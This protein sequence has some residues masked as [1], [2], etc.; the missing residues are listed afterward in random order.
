MKRSLKNL[1]GFPLEFLD[2]TRGNVKDFLFDE[3]TWTVRYIEADLGVIFPGKKVLIPRVF[4][5]DPD[6]RAKKFPIL[7][8]TS[9]IKDCPPLHENLSVSREYEKRMNDH[10]R[11]EHYWMKPNIPSAAIPLDA[12]PPRPVK[13]PLEK[14]DEEKIETNLRSF[15]EVMNYQINAKDDKLGKIVDIIVED[16][17]WM[18]MYAIVDTRKWMPLSKKVLIGIPWLESISYVNKELNIDLTTD[19]IKDAPEFDPYKPINEV[20]E[21][22][23]YNY[24]GAPVDA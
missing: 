5:E 16:L 14:L 1:I 7:L 11:V 21:K 6:W 24:Y 18:I 2:K 17:N 20:Y 12:I 22:K 9:Q 13:I 23:L 10:Y 15:N 4:F 8:N 3:N 19:S